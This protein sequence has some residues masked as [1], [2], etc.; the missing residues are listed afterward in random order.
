MI[1]SALILASPRIVFSRSCISL[2]ANR[3]TNLPCDLTSR[4]ALYQQPPSSTAP[5]QH[6]DRRARGR[7]P[8]TA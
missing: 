4:P 1:W 5:A 3:S 8:R 2:P 7:R 6:P